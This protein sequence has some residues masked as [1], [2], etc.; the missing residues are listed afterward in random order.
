MNLYSGYLKTALNSQKV[1]YTPRVGAG[2]SAEKYD[3]MGGT[4]VLHT[5]AKTGTLANLIS[6]VFPVETADDQN[7]TTCTFVTGTYPPFNPNFFCSLLTPYR[8][9]CLLIFTETSSTWHRIYTPP[10]NYTLAQ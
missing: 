10:G 1:Y 4:Q 9:S 5:A 3:L 8:L 6:Q 2:I 7:E